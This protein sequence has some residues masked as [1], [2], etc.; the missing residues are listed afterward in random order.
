M[1]RRLIVLAV[2][3]LLSATVATLAFS[4]ASFTSTSTTTVTASTDSVTG[5]LSLH[6]SSTD[7]AAVDKAGYGHQANIGANPF[8]A[9]GEDT[10]LAIDWGSY[11]DTN[12]TYTFNRT[13]T[14]RTSDT[15]PSGVTQVTVTAAAQQGSGDSFQPIRSVAISTMGSGGG[16]PSVTLGANQKRQVN[17][18]VRMKKNPWDPGDVFAPHIILTLTYTGGPAAYYRYDIPTSLTII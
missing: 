11:P 7:P 15:L 13:F 17:V 2:V 16:N 4:S 5:W 9:T 18:Q 8:L 12:T 14:L 10:T 1:S 6:S 3:A